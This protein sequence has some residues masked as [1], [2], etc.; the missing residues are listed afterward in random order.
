MNAAP[1][2]EDDRRPARLDGRKGIRKRSCAAAVEVRDVID[3]AATSTFRLAAVARRTG[4]GRQR[5]RMK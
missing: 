1:D 5:L 2:I 4:K 3:I